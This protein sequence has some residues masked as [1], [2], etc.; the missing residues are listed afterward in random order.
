MPYPLASATKQQWRRAV[1]DIL[2]DNWQGAFTTVTSTTVLLDTALNGYGPNWFQEWYLLITDTD[3]AAT[4]EFRIVDSFSGSTLTLRTAL[5]STTDLTAG[6]TGTYELHKYN[7]RW[8]T[9]A[10]AIA[11]QKTF[12][13][14][15]RPITGFLAQPD[16]T[17]GVSSVFSF[18]RNMLR[19][20]NV[21]LVGL[22]KV[23]DSFN[24]AASASS[25][26]GSWVAGTLSASIVYSAGG[27][28]W[29]ITGLATPGGGDPGEQLY[30]ATN[31][32]RDIITYPIDLKDG[33]ISASLYAA[34]TYLELCFRIRENYAGTIVGTEMLRLRLTTTALTL[35]K[36]DAGTDSEL[37]TA[38]VTA[39]ASIDQPVAVQ[40]FGRTVLVWHAGVLVISHELSDANLKYLEY[41]GLGILVRTADT[42]SR[43]DDFA[44]F[45]LLPE[46]RV[47]DWEQDELS[48]K[49]TIHNALSQNYLLQVDGG[50][51]LSALAADTN[52]GD[53]GTIASDTTATLEIQTTDPAWQLL[54][55]QGALE[56]LRMAYQNAHS[57]GE[58]GYYGGLLGDMQKRVDA[59]QR[60]SMPKPAPSLRMPA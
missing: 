37:A 6:A 34:N 25:P 42:T 31:I 47:F 20:W 29:G 15:Y 21:A 49:L 59:L 13:L 7:P 50:S 32:A 24:R 60:L 56:V 54:T 2:N 16:S 39:T 33:Y 36:Y 55:H 12:A 26:G 1:A 35:R 19:I 57:D 22:L 58:R 18:P 14:V 45:S 9:T 11:I 17:T 30:S 48:Q 53:N 3:A 51:L 8:Y 38:T 41:T 23:R 40:F 43:V 28:T 27:S 4:G 10:L 46:M 52:R 5:S 44:A